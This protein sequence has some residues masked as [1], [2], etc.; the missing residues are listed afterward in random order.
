MRR[1]ELIGQMKQEREVAGDRDNMCQGHRV[2]LRTVCLHI[3]VYTVNLAH[4]IT[5]IG[6]RRLSD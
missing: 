3:Y 5:A 2:R 4:F 6:D 1:V